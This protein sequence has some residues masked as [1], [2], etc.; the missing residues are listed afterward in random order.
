MHNNTC[1]VKVFISLHTYTCGICSDT[2]SPSP[3]GE[4]VPVVSSQ[5]GKPFFAVVGVV[6][7]T[8]SSGNHRLVFSGAIASLDSS[9]NTY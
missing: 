7:D 1:V 8:D 2:L 6:N 3:V 4:F 9:G 5:I